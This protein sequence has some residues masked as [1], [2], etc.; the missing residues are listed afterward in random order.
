MIRSCE[1]IETLDEFEEWIGSRANALRMGLQETA[2]IVCWSE[3]E[4]MDPELFT[5]LL[6]KESAKIKND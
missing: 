2:D 6:E 3:G 4:L 5:A 1:N